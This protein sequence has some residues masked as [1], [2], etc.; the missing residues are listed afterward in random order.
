MCNQYWHFKPHLL[1]RG[2]QNRAEGH[3]LQCLK[4]SKVTCQRQNYGSE[5]KRTLK[6]WIW[7][8]YSFNLAF[9]I[10]RLFREFWILWLI[11]KGLLDWYTHIIRSISM[12][13]DNSK[14]D[15]H[16]EPS[17]T[18][19]V[20]SYRYSDVLFLIE[21]K[22]SKCSW[23]NSKALMNDRKEVSKRSASSV[24]G[25]R[26]SATKQKQS[27]SLTWPRWLKKS[28]RELIEDHSASF[29]PPQRESLARLNT[30]AAIREP[31]KIMSISSHRGGDKKNKKKN[32]TPPWDN[33]GSPGSDGNKIAPAA[34]G[35]PRGKG[36]VRGALRGRDWKNKSARGSEDIY[37][38]MYTGCMRERR[39]NAYIRAVVFVARRLPFFL[40]V[41][42][43]LRRL[44][45]GP[46]LLW[47]LW[48]FWIFVAGRHV[49]FS[50]RWNGGGCAPRCFLCNF[51]T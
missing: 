1:N 50:L 45:W 19:N 12:Q 20:P 41:S 18:S 30:Y 28:R 22:Y 47:N 33:R 27:A 10:T 24:S 29:S 37:T 4:E 7:L 31:I 17:C 51:L 46:R 49:N 40:R 43:L 25:S 48:I 3:W 36:E 32:R 13:L 42:T 16:Q 2:P 35:W 15:I 34:A 9:K 14:D 8:W 26:A 39:V 23:K 5:I 38:C 6:T 21:V 44:P 11:M